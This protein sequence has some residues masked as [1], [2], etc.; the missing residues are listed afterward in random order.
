MGHLQLLG[1]AGIALA[2]TLTACGAD[3]GSYVREN[4]SI[5]DAL[6]EVPGAERVKVESSPYYEGDSAWSP[7]SGY[8]TTV[9]YQAPPEMT[10]QEVMD[11]YLESMD[12]DWQA[13]VEEI[14]VVDLV[15]GERE[16]TAL[17]PHFTRGTAMVSVNTDNMYAGGPH[18]FEVVVDHRGAK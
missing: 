17:M 14:P 3:K 4:K 5:V 18:T 9:I 11:F 12:E 8:T 13:H 1:L 15:T 10:D 16:G 2:L 7:V 6:P